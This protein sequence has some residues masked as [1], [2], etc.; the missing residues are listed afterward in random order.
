MTPDT[1]ISVGRIV[2]SRG[3]KGEVVVYPLS[4]DPE[5]FKSF[6]QVV[7]TAK[8]GTTSLRKLDSVRIARRRGRVEVHARFAGVESR[9]EAE[10]LRGETLGVRSEDLPLDEDEY[11]L[12]DLI[13]MDVSTAAGEMLGRVTDVRRLPAQD[14][15]VVT[16]DDGR[17]SLIPDVPEFV[18]KSQLEEGRL[19]VMPIEGLLDLS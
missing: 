13:G 11:F 18:D 19:V 10:Q 9:D 2:R 6:E 7:A 16:G 8:D 14:V 5:R 15:I 4:D 17:E 1:L 12:F 3:L